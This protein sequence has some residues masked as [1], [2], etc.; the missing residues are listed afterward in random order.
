MGVT[1]INLKSTEKKGV[2]LIQG[3]QRM[4]RYDFMQTAEMSLKTSVQI[5]Q[6]AEKYF[7]FW[8]SEFV[9]HYRTE[10]TENY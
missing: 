8:Y 3:I 10:Y 7:K 2:L 4:P 9:C 1:W 6:Q 5:G